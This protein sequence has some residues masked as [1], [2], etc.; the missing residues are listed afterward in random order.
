LGSDKLQ[1]KLQFFTEAFLYVILSSIIALAALKISFPYL[2][3]LLKLN[4]PFETNGRFAAIV[5]ATILVT[6]LGAGFYPAIYLSSFSS[7]KVLKG[8]FRA[9]GTSVSLKNVLVAVQLVISMSLIGCALVVLSQLHF[10]NNKN[11]GFSYKNLVVITLGPGQQRENFDVLKNRLLRHPEITEVTSAINYPGR[12]YI[13]RK[14]WRPGENGKDGTAVQMGFVGAD[15]FKVFGMH[16]IKGRGFGDL[17]PGQLKNA[18]IVNAMAVRRL[19]LHPPVIG[20]KISRQRPGYD[21][22]QDF[23][24]IA[25]VVNNFNS[26]SLREPIK[27]IVL[28]PVSFHVNLIAKVN[29]SHKS[30]KAVLGIIRKDFKQVNPKSPFV[31][32]FLGNTL[33]KSYAPDEE[34]FEIFKIFSL[35]II[36]ISCLGLFGLIA[37]STQQRSKEFA[38]RK[39]L[40]ATFHQLA[41]LISRDII[42]LIGIAFLMACPVIYLG[43]R[44]WLS[45]FVYKTSISPFTFLIAGLTVCTVAFLTIGYQVIKVGMV[46]P[47]QNIRNE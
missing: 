25:G 33:A 29:T 14:L 18:V 46:K 26:A 11:L 31:Y 9:V 4:I 37:Y 23:K 10:I 22:K 28:Y 43:M 20:K 35:L 42:K 13:R 3:H 8:S 21:N 36:L 15:F 30:K 45:G 5:L 41:M 34:L 44:Y 2:D 32:S 24:V 19:G 40:G 47:A 7:S 17:G 1:V 27:P 39:V 6:G 12:G 38:I 16:I